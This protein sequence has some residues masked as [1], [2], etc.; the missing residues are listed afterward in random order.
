MLRR[1]RPAA[2]AT[3]PTESTAAV[4]KAPHKGASAPP[5][6]VSAGPGVQM[7]PAISDA[8]GPESHSY[9]Y[10]L[11]SNEEQQFRK[12]V[13]ALASKQVEAWAAKQASSQIGAAP[14]KTAP[15]KGAHKAP[16]VEFEDVQLKAFDLSSSN[17]PV[18]V[19]TAKAR[20]PQ[21][22]AATFGNGEYTVTLVARDDIYDELHVAFS[23]VTDDQH[24]DLVSKYELIDVVD[25]DGD[26]RGEL[27]FREI[28]DAGSAFVIYRVI[29]NQLWPL[30]E[31][32]PGA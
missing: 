13:L 29:G 26:G 12:K 18:L 14:H 15:A 11:D 32:K 9:L 10:D 30:Y 19:L 1:G 4:E 24:L 21:S 22:K 23:K 2:S 7:I 17:Q 3:A 27:L 8:G 5:S 31:G 20:L 28:S 25:A 16:P 6:L